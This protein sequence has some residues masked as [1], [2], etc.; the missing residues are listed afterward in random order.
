M[1]LIS[2]RGSSEPWAY[3]GDIFLATSTD[4]LKAHI[5]SNNQLVSKRSISASQQHVLEEY[6]QELEKSE[7]TVILDN[8]TLVT[9]KSTQCSNTISEPVIKNTSPTQK[10]KENSNEITQQKDT[11][12]NTD[13]GVLFSYTMDEHERWANADGFAIAQEIEKSPFWPIGET[14]SPRGPFA[15]FSEDMDL[16]AVLRD[17][18][19]HFKQSKTD[20]IRFLGLL[21]T[22]LPIFDHLL[23]ELTDDCAERLAHL[24]FGEV[25]IWK[26]NGTDHF[27]QS[28]LDV[29]ILEY[30]EF[31]GWFELF[32]IPVSFTKAFELQA[33]YRHDMVAY[34]EGF[35]KF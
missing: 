4:E 28:L 30:P 34:K 16:E 3:H 9:P 33:S 7:Q 2:K 1:H 21:F 23:D 25:V 26:I 31:Q 17:V 11:S 32:Q 24:V 15:R 10:K 14:S 19:Y 35:Q 12:E 29:R 20:F 8:P 13:D 18:R 6:I 5:N 27:R 22:G